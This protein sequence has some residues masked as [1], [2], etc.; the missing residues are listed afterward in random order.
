[1]T[2]QT[3][4]ESRGK[5]DQIK[6]LWKYLKKKKKTTSKVIMHFTK[7]QNMRGHFRLK[8]KED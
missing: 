8:R 7:S 5:K 2:G 4:W 3:Y 6:H 1:M